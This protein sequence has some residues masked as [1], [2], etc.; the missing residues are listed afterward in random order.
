MSLSQLYVT[1]STMDA[2][3]QESR[4]I[5]YTGLL[6][7]LLQTSSVTLHSRT[8]TR[9]K[10]VKQAQWQPS[11]NAICAATFMRTNSANIRIRIQ[12]DETTTC[13]Y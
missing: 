12:T 7:Y 6:S 1:W 9:G 5:S 13:A 8:T 4:W 11:T 3:R 10:N 2:I